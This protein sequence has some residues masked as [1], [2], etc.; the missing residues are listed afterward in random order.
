MRLGGETHV[1]TARRASRRVA[2]VIHQVFPGTPCLDAHTDRLLAVGV[3]W[4]TARI[5]HHDPRGPSAS[6]S[7]EFPTIRSTRQIGRQIPTVLT[8]PKVRR[9]FGPP[10]LL[11]VHAH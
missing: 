11:R 6:A 1:T 2:H 8:Q 3:T 10:H 7:P 4:A 5:A 9:Q